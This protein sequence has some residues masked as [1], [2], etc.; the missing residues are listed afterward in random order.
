ML[1]GRRLPVESG[2]AWL[3][4][5]CSDA[6]M[7]SE[8]QGWDWAGMNLDDGTALTAFQGYL[9]MTGYANALKL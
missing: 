4:H 9:E 8:A 7:H 3:D 1:G 6:L 2:R 5:E